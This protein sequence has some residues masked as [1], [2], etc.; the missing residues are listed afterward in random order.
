M[1]RPLRFVGAACGLTLLLAAPVQAQLNGNHTLGDFG[2][3]AGTQPRQ[4]F[5]PR[6]STCEPTPTPSRMLTETPSACP[7][8]LPGAST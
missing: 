4:G 7:R 5:S 8:T 2:V 6:C 3:Q 1:R